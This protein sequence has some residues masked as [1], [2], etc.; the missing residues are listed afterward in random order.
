MAGQSD[1]FNPG[2]SDPLIGDVSAGGTFNAADMGGGGIGQWLKQN[3]E[4]L[5]KIIGGIPLAAG[6]FHQ[7]SSA[8]T[9]KQLAQLAGQERNQSQA[10]MAPLQTGILPPGA[11]QSVDAAKQ[12]ERGQIASTYARLGLSGSTMEGQALA[13]ANRNAAAQSF[14]FANQ[15]NAQGWPSRVRRALSPT[16]C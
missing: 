15:L 6:M 9:Q 5:S 16:N 10:L 1:F 7:D 2:T 14:G 4:M 8:G 13:A 11:Q 12:A 3:P